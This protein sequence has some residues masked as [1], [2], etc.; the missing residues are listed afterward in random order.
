MT[1][2]LARSI[3]LAIVSALILFFAGMYV[4]G[5]NRTCTVALSS[6]G[7]IPVCSTSFEQQIGN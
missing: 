1:M 5:R 2:T 4:G 3:T 7:W 6:V